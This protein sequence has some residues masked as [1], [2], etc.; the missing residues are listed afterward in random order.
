[1]Y[2]TFDGVDGKQSYRVQNTELEE[3]TD[4]AVDSISVTLTAVL[5][6]A[7]LQL[8]D[9]PI[10]LGLN[11]MMALSAFFASHWAA[12]STN[13]LIF[14]HIDV[15]EAQWS[16]VAIHLSTALGGSTFWNTVICEAP[17]IHIK[18]VVCLGTAATLLFASADNVT[19]ALGMRETPLE[20]NGLR[21]PRAPLTLWPLVTYL[22]INGGALLCFVNGLLTL[23]S[24]P[25]MLIVGL[26]MGRAGTE[27]IVQKLARKHGPMIVGT[28]SFTPLA[29]FGL[30]RI[31]P[32]L[33][34]TL[35][36]GAWTLVAV[37]TLDVCTFHDHVTQ[38]LATARDIQRFIML[39][40]PEKEAPKDTGFY[41]CGGNLATMRKEWE[42]FASDSARVKATYF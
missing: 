34:V 21:I 26:A 16:M 10:L 11:L 18:D 30:Y 24:A 17:L 7:A 31:S 36:M 39:D 29:L 35:T 23:Q 4:H 6:A 28:A 42:A 5:L 25:T 19:V 38:D 20:A 41:V 37:L 3:Y 2:Q 27:M 32:T 22:V 15:T 14:G 9:S 40:G 13:S 33:P 12:H 1:M 8:G